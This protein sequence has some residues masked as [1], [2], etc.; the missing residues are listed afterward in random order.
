[1]LQKVIFSFVVLIL[2]LTQAF[3]QSF[4]LSGRVIDDDTEEGLPFCNVF[5]LGTTTG[6]STDIDGYYTFE[7]DEKPSDTLK[8]T[9]IGYA[10]RVKHIGDE[11]EQS[12]T[13]RMKASGLDLAEVVVIAGENPAN[14]IV[15]GIIKNK[16]RNNIAEKE[17]YRCETY[18]KLEMDLDNID[19]LEDRKIMRHFDFVFDN[20]DT[21]SDIKP[22]LP[23]FITETL[24]DVYHVKGSP[25]KEIPTAI[26]VSGVENQTVIDMLNTFQEKFN[27]YDNWL[28]IL[29]KQFVSPFSDSGLSYYEYYIQDTMMIDGFRSIKLK[30]KPKRK[31]EN[32]F[33]G[34]FWVAD[35]VYAVQRADMRMTPD[36]NINLVHRIIIY[37][38]FGLVNDSVFV[39][40]KEKGIIDFAAIKNAP[41]IIGRRTNTYRNFTFDVPK[42]DSIY[43]E[44]D[45][46]N[47]YMPELKKD[48]DFWEEARHEKLS[49]NELKIYDMVDSIQNVPIFKT[50]SKIIYT[51]GT[52]WYVMGPIEWGNLYTIYSSNSVQGP[53]L[54]LDLGSSNNLSKILRVWGHGAYG[55]RDRKFRYGL[56]YQWN[57]RKGVKRTIMGGSY[58]NDVSFTNNSS[59]DFGDG[60]VFTSLYRRNVPEKLLHVKEGKIFLEHDWKKGW[61]NRL[62]FL[63]RDMDPFGFPDD[64]ARGFEFR[65]IP[66]LNNPMVEDT[67]VQAA[68]IILNTRYAFGERVLQGEFEEISLGSKYPI[69]TLQLLAGIPIN[70]VKNVYQKVVLGVEHYFYLNPIGWTEY[71]FKTGKVFGTLPY[72]LLETHP[73]N[74]TFF[75]SEN[76][77]NS[78]GRFEFVSD[79]YASLHMQHHF[80]G[81]FFNKIPLIRKLDFRLVTDFKAVIGKLS[82][83]N[84]AVNFIDHPDPAQRVNI[85]SPG[86]VPYMEVGVGIEN[87]LKLLRVEG[88][89]RLNYRDRPNAQNFSVRVAVDFNF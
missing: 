44:K 19:R 49:E 39:P 12:F 29:G 18:Q 24:Y 52:G 88:V 42:M 83:D 67:T 53:R 61:S 47:Y 76:A 6:V 11:L 87:I 14:D 77:F 82:K 58:K 16:P 80:D 46:E 55:F 2:V 21:T 59:E 41:G 30:F 23:A 36:V 63:Y 33:Y 7:L 74:E 65:Y 22:F 51:V 37:E 73:G 68:E 43:K 4:K 75:F 40:V 26:K 32:T 85:V 3:G 25:L 48:D 8:I 17:S 10:D 56:N 13:F 34:H 64:P 81:F 28:N 62:T 15:R 79:L 5:F 70:G 31:Q 50:Y 66:N 38:E 60:D 1:M 45:P 35:S 20:V 72:L 86:P 84:R 78:M 57:I 69:I 27:V 9:A 89:W 54:R 71:E